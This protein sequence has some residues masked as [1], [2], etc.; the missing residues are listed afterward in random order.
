[1]T[2]IT[3]FDP[4]LSTGIVTG[5][6]NEDSHYESRYIWQIPGGPQ[7]LM[8][9]LEDNPYNFGDLGLIGGSI[10]GCEKFVPRPIDG[11]S[12][13]LESTIPLVGEGVLIGRRVMP[14][15][16]FGNWQPAGAQ[17]LRKGKDPAQSKKFSDDLLKEKGLWLTGEDVGQPDA[18]DAISSTKHIIHFLCHK[19]RHEPTLEWIYG[20]GE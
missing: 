5:W 12:H 7:G 18:N 1:M 15:Y 4:G 8:D 9:W 17:V 3:W 20:G 16:P 10:V 19:L 2:Y 13:T 6:F 14:A 11:G